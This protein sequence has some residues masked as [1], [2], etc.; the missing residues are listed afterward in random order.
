M[1][2]SLSYCFKTF[3]RAYQLKTPYLD[4]TA[5]VTFDPLNFMARLALMVPKPRGKFVA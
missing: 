2:S 5:H 4:D 3:L 1:D